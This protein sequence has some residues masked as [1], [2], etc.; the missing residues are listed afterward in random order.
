MADRL[1]K[2]SGRTTGFQCLLS[3]PSNDCCSG[4]LE[5]MPGFGISV[6]RERPLTRKAESPGRPAA[7]GRF[8]LEVMFLLADDQI[9]KELFR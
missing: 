7:K 4:S 9:R 6:I 1:E 2:C 5:T 8:E 3:Y